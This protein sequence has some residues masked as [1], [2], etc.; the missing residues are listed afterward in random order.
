MPLQCRKAARTPSRWWTSTHRAPCQRG[1]PPAAKRLG[2]DGGGI[3]LSGV[4]GWRLSTELDRLRGG[5]D[6]VI[7]DSP[8]HAE[9]DAKAAIRAAD[10]ILVPVQ[11]SPM[12]LWATKPTLDVARREKTP[13]RVVLNRVPPRGNLVDEVI[14]EL[15]A[16]ELEVTKARL[17]NRQAYASS[18]MKGLGVVE[19]SGRSLAAREIEALADEI[20]AFASKG[21]Q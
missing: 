6:Y 14:A 1:T 5:V 21:G 17:G 13:A 18:M 11:P 10:M 19:T 2:E 4:T 7:V 12:D 3:R 9:T 15:D 16:M 8:P 20:A